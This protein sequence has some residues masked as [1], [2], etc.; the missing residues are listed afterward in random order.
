MPRLSGPLIAKV[1]GLWEASGPR[2][3]ALRALSLGE[4]GRKN[5]AHNLQNCPAGKCLLGA[6]RFQ[7]PYNSGV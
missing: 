1:A 6:P 4:V 5:E 7:I 3:V 2:V